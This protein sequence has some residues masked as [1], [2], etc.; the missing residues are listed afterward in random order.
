MG[1]LSREQTYEKA[2][3]GE[4]WRGRFRECVRTKEG[5]ASAPWALVGS[6]VLLGDWV[7]LPW[8]D[9]LTVAERQAF[10]L[11]SVAHLKARVKGTRVC[12]E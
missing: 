1:Y 3:R 12:A 8:G 10:P 9:W 7:P 11:D 2:N 4:A 6:Q 5:W